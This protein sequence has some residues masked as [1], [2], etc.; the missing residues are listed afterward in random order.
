[1][2]Y[3]ARGEVKK[4][5]EECDSLKIFA[6]KATSAGLLTADALAIIDKE[7]GAL[8]DDS[9]AKALAAPKPAAEELLTDV[10]ISY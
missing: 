9:V 7:V 10:Y 3:R 5:R 4:L 6:Q 8:I 2:T 1:M